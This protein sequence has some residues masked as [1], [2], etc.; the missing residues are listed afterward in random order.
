MCA[1]HLICFVVLRLASQAQF[2]DS[3]APAT[4]M[5]SPMQAVH[6]KLSACIRNL[7]PDERKQLPHLLRGFDLAKAMDY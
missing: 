2:M 7:T 1:A 4:A 3:Y 5:A 6:D